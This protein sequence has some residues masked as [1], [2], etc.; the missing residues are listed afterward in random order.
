ME[1]VEKKNGCFLIENNRI[2]DKRG[3]FQ[4]AVNFD[5]LRDMGVKFEQIC[6]LNHS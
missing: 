2:T 1:I 4:V 3:W 6:Q 5:E